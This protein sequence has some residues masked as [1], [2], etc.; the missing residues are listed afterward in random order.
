MSQSRDNARLNISPL[1]LTLQDGLERLFEVIQSEQF[2]FIVNGE[3]LK[4]TIAEAVLISPTIHQRLQFCPEI[5][6]FRIDDDKLTLKYFS[7]F[8]D[9]VHSRIV[10][11]FSRE[12]QISFLSICGLLGNIRLT[13]LLL[14]SLHGMSE[15]KESAVL[16]ICDIDSNVC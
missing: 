3:E 13:F 8:L 7:R 2:E 11:D 5:R 14:E 6:T 10:G 4:I 15:D 9:F 1:F 12:E 16:E